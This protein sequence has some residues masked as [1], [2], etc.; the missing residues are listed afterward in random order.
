M[1]AVSSKSEAL[2]PEGKPVQCLRLFLSVDVS[3]STDY[4]NKNSNFEDYERHWPRFYESFFEN[5]PNLF[6]KKVAS[7]FPTTPGRCPGV[8]KCLGD[9]IIFEDKVTGP[10]DCHKLVAAFCLAISE[11]D[12]DLR[13]DQDKFKNSGLRVKGTCWSAGFPVRN[14]QL[15]LHLHTSGDGS[16]CDYVGPEMDTGF[17][18][19]KTTR[20][21]RVAIS[22]DLA[23]ILTRHNT[24]VPTLCFH[25]VGWEVLKGVFGDKPYPVIWVRE[26]SDHPHLLPW[27]GHI[28]SFT[29][30]FRRT[31]SSTD[32]SNLQSL[33]HKIRLELPQLKLIKPYFTRSEMPETHKKF[34][35]EYRRNLNQDVDMAEQ[36][37]P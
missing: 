19:S 28:C 6:A 15:N 17:R 3:G 36:I 32:A 10:D 9:E 26:E 8:W 37:S 14:S 30:Q 24:F 13:T 29:E 18:V 27:E 1:E 20:P 7:Q 22:M 16:T 2:S 23:D 11:Y 35:E 34:W 31:Q 5:F 33:I 21:G 12:K 4:K 25:H